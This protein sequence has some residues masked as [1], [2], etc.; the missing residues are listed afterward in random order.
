MLFAVKVV[1]VRVFIG[2][3]FGAGLAEQM[4]LI[5]DIFLFLPTSD[6]GLFPFELEI[7]DNLVLDHREIL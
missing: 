7:V 1:D 4:L 3:I 5:D 6:C 2:K